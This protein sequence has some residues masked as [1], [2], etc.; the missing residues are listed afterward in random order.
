MPTNC[1]IALQIL[2]FDVDEFMDSFMKNCLLFYDK[3]YA[4]YSTNPWGYKKSNITNSTS[5][6]LIKKNGVTILP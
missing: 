3:I 2:L 5:I 1:K 4:T 6:N